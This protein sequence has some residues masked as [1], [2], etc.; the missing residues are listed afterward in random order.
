MVGSGTVY[1]AEPQASKN[2][3]RGAMLLLLFVVPAI[4]AN[5]VS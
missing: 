2:E 1:P 5:S 4:V 3:S